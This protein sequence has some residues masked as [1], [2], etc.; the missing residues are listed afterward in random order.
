[1]IKQG[2]RILM[3]QPNGGAVHIPEIVDHLRFRTSRWATL[4]PRTT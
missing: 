1:M 4:Q 2:H 3:N